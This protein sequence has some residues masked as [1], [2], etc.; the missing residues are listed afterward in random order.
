VDWI[1][2]T[3]HNVSQLTPDVIKFQIRGF[4]CSGKNPDRLHLTD[5]IIE[6]VMAD[7][8]FNVRK[9]IDICNRELNFPQV[10]LWPAVMEALTFKSV[11]IA[12]SA[13]LKTERQRQAVSVFLRISRAT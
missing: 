10:K 8:Q 1:E 9:S 4:I 13:G 2:M 7:S 6:G 11:R 5:E 3:R 12:T